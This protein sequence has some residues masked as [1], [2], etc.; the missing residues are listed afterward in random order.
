MQPELLPVITQSQPCVVWRRGLEGRGGK[1]PWILTG[2][3]TWANAGLQK[4][5]AVPNARWIS[6]QLPCKSCAVPQDCLGQGGLAS[7]VQLKDAL[8]GIA[9]CGG[10]RRCQLNRAKEA[11]IS[12]DA[13][14]MA[15]V[16]TRKSQD[17]LLSLAQEWG[18]VSAPGM[19][20][21]QGATGCVQV[22]CTQV[23]H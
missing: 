5:Q 2:H 23:L 20:G 10:P 1:P 11:G 19:L 8:N 9:A 7:P 4:P 12:E 21:T 18:R 6:A 22:A 16:P 14:L 3:H 13:G 17:I 15:M